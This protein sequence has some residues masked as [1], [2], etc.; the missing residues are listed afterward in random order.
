[1][2][3]AKGS[4]GA[5]R[6]VGQ[7]LDELFKGAHVECGPKVSPGAA[8]P[9]EVTTPLADAVPFCRSPAAA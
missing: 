7:V 1:M 5:V 4:K 2:Y 6:R 3:A 8:T 9:T